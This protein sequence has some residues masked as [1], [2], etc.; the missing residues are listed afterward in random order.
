MAFAAACIAGWAKAYPG[1]TNSSMTLRALILGG[2]LL[3]WVLIRPGITT[4]L[5]FWM[6]AS[7]SFYA[8]L[9]SS[10][11]L[12]S[13]VLI[14]VLALAIPVWLDIWPPQ[15]Q[16]N[17]VKVLGLYCIVVLSCSRLGHWIRKL[18]AQA[19]NGL[20][21]PRTRLYNVQGFMNYGQLLLEDA[22][23][24]KTEFSLVLIN[25]D[26]LR[27]FTSRHGK[28]MARMFLKQ[29]IG[30]IRELAPENAIVARTDAN[31]FSIAM[32]GFT[33]QQAQE[34]ITQRLGR[35]PKLKL[36]RDRSKTD[37]AV[38]VLIAQA[39]KET[40]SLEQIHLRLHEELLQAKLSPEKAEGQSSLMM[41][42]E[43]VRAYSRRIDF[44]L[45]G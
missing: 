43:D 17:S 24:A 19:A 23:N 3:P 25:C 5:C 11:R 22:A 20:I 27:G 35:P 6:F 34:Q 21:D 40:S 33:A 31:E 37:L 44:E 12:G 42:L 16:E 29:V 38:D 45:P 36:G 18:D 9:L 41:M 14:N 1:G 26:E 32:P 30:Q 4:E 15:N 8:L 28:Q 2:A 7:S 10:S 13:F 39:S